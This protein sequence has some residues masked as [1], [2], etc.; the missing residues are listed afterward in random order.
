VANRKPK[1]N[2]EITAR[3]GLEQG[4]HLGPV[5]SINRSLPNTRYFLTVGDWSAKVN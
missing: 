2:V 4:R 1:K 3:Y 5:C